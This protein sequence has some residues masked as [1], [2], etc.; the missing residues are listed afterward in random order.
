MRESLSREWLSYSRTNNFQTD[1]LPIPYS[2]ETA[3]AKLPAHE[4]DHS[5]YD[6]N[7]RLQPALSMMIH[8]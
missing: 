4:D 6:A 3:D 5:A 8:L 1:Q 7:D 2:S